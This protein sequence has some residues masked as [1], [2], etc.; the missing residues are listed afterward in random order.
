VL[1]FTG[2]ALNGGETT[3]GRP[4]SDFLQQRVDQGTWSALC[5]TV[6]PSPE[7]ESGRCALE[8]FFG[9]VQSVEVFRPVRVLLVMQVDITACPVLVRRL[10]NQ[11]C[12]LTKFNFHFWSLPVSLRFVSSPQH[13]S[14]YSLIAPFL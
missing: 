12:K 4:D 5:T 6:A 7:G 11:D 13:D 8:I 2:V 1:I 3:V 9:L 14:R 10:Q